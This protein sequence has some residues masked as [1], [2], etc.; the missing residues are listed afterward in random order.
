MTWDDWK[1]YLCNYFSE[2]LNA[3]LKQ[4]FDADV[5]GDIHEDLVKASANGKFNMMLTDCTLI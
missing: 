2:R 5:T 4:L 3:M 1:I